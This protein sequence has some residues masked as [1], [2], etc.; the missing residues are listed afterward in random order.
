VTIIVHDPRAGRPHHTIRVREDHRHD[1]RAGVPRSGLIV[2]HLP[3]SH[4]EPFMQA[5]MKSPAA[6]VPDVMQP[7]VALGSAAKKSVPARTLWLVLIRA[8]QINGCSWCVDNHTREAKKE[9]DSDERIN[10]VAA[11]RDTPF[12]S[13][14]ERAALALAE[15]TTRLNDR[16]DPVSNEVWDNAATH[17]DEPTLAALIMNIGIVNMWNRINVATRQLPGGWHR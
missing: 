13:D 12:F 9:G 6:L 2:N 10:A 16:S 1:S 4:K 5:R 3:K 7:L 11:W 17:F 8:S 14:A 15:A